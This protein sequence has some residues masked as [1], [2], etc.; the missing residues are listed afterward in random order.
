[1]TDR[2]NAITVVLEKD[3]RD[4]D[5]E[6]ILTALR[7]TKGVLSVTPNVANESDHI[8]ELRARQKLHEQ[9]SDV[10]WPSSQ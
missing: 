3:F 4:D 2:I 5:C 9:L 8:A 1:M 6:S 10:L 7:M